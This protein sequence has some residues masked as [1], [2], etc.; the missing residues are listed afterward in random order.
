MMKF[1]NVSDPSNSNAAHIDSIAVLDGKIHALVS[2]PHG[3]VPA[4]IFR[5]EGDEWVFVGRGP[6]PE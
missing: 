1:K 5:L 3:K 2:A 4:G 6:A